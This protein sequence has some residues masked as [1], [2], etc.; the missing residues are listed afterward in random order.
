MLL[1][2]KYDG[3]N[4]WRYDAGAA[5]Q[6]MR[7]MQTIKSEIII[8]GDTV[9]VNGETYDKR[10]TGKVEEPKEVHPFLKDVPLN[11]ERAF[12]LHA[13]GVGRE[14]DKM[15]Q[16]EIDRGTVSHNREYLEELD[17]RRV[18]ETALKRWIGENNIPVASEE[19][20]AD[21]NMLKYSL[22][23]NSDSGNVAGCEWQHYRPI[24]D[25]HLLSHDDFL[26]VRDNCDALIRTAYD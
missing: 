17:R 23:F 25:I 19:Q 8:D 11:G 10:Q 24:G 22:Q 15:D 4:P 16:R 2:S 3:R 5:N 9:I 20:M 12:I 18:A 26:K 6:E 14:S 21:G 1:V 7:I 13:H